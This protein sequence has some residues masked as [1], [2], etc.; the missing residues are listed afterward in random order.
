MALLLEHLLEVC[1]QF[2][3][4]S[5]LLGGRDKLS[6]FF[7]ICLSLSPKPSCERW[8]AERRQEER[9]TW[10]GEDQSYHELTE[11][12]LWGKRPPRLPSRQ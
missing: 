4:R 9:K 12:W 1:L 3:A 5:R 8:R 6:G 11:H 7:S 2:P 10:G